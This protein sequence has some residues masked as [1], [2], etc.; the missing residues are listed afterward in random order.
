MFVVEFRIDSPFLRDALANVPEATITLE[1]LYPTEDSDIVHFWVKDC[2][3]TTFEEG[4]AAD[5]TVTDAVQLAETETRSL[6]RVTCTDYGESLV[7]F[8]MWSELDISFLDGT[9]THEGWEVR[10]RMPDREVLQKYRDI[11]EERDLR[12]RLNSIYEE[13]ETATTADAQL[14][15]VQREALVT[16]YE[17][18]YFAVPR[19]ASLADVATRFGVSS[20]AVS[21]RIRRGTATL[22]KTTL[23]RASG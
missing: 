19:Q 21:E 10:L 23:L 4:L 18:G 8:P 20:Q 16:A 17:L 9:G 22:I 15:I 5:S 1:E 12:F 13:R 14:T 2:D 11:C 3:L 7:T 6:Y